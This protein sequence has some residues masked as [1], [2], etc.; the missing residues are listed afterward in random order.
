MLILVGILAL[1]GAI[2]SMYARQQAEI[3]QNRVT[4]LQ[5]RIAV[6]EAKTN[7]RIYELE[8]FIKKMKEL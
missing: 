1:F 4:G 6:E 2:A 8:Q 7:I 3:A 5:Q